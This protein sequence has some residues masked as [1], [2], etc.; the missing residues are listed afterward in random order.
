MFLWK[1]E[2]IRFME[3][4]SERCD[5]HKQLAT[6]I[7][8]KLPE[9]AAICDAGCGLGYLS[10]ALSPYC[11]RVTAVDV[12]RDALEVLEN[13]R[14]ER[15]CENIR[16]RCGNI[17]GLPPEAPYDAMVFC[18]FGSA[19]SI[20]HI[21]KEQCRGKI[22]IIKKNWEE[23]RFTI[24]HKKLVHETFAV[25]QT[26]LSLLGIPFTAEA[27][28]LEMGQPLCSLSEAVSFFHIY[29][30]D[31]NLGEITEETVRPLLRETGDK[32]LPY[33][34]PQKKQMGIITLD[35]ENIPDA[36]KRED[37]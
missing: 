34:L 28:S 3:E 37:E 18:F 17:S 4:A 10:L 25:L 6:M 15:G 36:I 23:H 20:L 29:S 16:V 5:Y 12:S 1:P 8:T 9:N 7:A 26:K 2:M 33:Y 19:G 30:Q 13:K 27:F 22:I 32:E 24:G 14:R 21:A 31:D 11:R 35:T